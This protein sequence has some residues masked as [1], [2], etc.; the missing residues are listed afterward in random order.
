MMTNNGSRKPPVH[1]SSG[2]PAARTR[3]CAVNRDE[4][5]IL[6]KIFDTEDMGTID[7][8]EFKAALRALGLHV[9]SEDVQQML[10]SVHRT[11][12]DGIT[13]DDFCALAES[14]MP[15]RLSRESLYQT[16]ELFGGCQNGYL[17]INNLKVACEELGEDIS[18]GELRQMIAYADQDG[19]GLVTFEDFER[20]MHRKYDPFGSDSD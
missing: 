4:L 11:A 9:T 1:L 16:F 7:I 20:I 12:K 6:F 10:L 19:D 13:F 17:D 18:D 14:R 15:E 8:R 5:G 2:K 3:N